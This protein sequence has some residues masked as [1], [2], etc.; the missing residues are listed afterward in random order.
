MTMCTIDCSNHNLCSNGVIYSQTIFSVCYLLRVLVVR[1]LSV[2]G[3]SFETVEFTGRHTIYI[4]FVA[5]IVT[6]LFLTLIESISTCHRYG[7]A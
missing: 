3:F 7:H 4:I 1:E 5:M 6:K 2:V